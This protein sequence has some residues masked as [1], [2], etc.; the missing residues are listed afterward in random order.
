M[1]RSLT[2]PN[3]PE[4][5]IFFAVLKVENAIIG[6]MQRITYL[7]RQLFIGEGKDSLCFI[8]FHINNPLEG[9]L[10]ADVLHPI[11]N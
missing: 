6:L 5:V 2:L 7:A 9:I 1:T 3:D 8:I 4:Q 11:A 10:L